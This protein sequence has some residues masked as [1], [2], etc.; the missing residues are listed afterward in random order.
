MVNQMMPEEEFM[1]PDTNYMILMEELRARIM[2]IQLDMQSIRDP[3]I[4]GFAEKKYT[5]LKIEY[6]RLLKDYTSFV[7]LSGDLDRVENEGEENGVL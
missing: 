7:L 3:E 6:F 5:K 2:N 1:N 4:K